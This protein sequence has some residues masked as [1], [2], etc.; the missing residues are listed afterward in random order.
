MLDILRTIT[1]ELARIGVVVDP[2][3]VVEKKATTL[4]GPPPD[5]VEIFTYSFTKTNVILSWE[6]P[7]ES[8]LRYEIR[9]GTV[10]ED[11]FKLFITGNLSAV[12]DPIEV[13]I[14]TYL[15]KSI[16]SSGIRSISSTSIEV[17]VPALGL[18]DID[19]RTLENQVLL[20]WEEPIST[21]RISHYIIRREGTVLVSHNVNTFWAYSE[22]AEGTYIY[23]VST[24]D[25]AGNESLSVSVELPVSSPADFEIEDEITSNFSGI[26]SNGVV[27]D[28]GKLYINVDTTKTY[29]EHFDDNSWISPQKQIDADYNLWI[30]PTLLAGYYEEVFI[31]SQILNNVTVNLSWL[32]EIVKGNFSFGLD[33]RVSDDGNTY[34]TAFTEAVFYAVSVRYI[35]ARI[36]FTSGSDEDLLAFGNLKCSLSVKREQDGGEK[37]VL[38]SDNASGGTTVDFNKSFLSIESITVAPKATTEIKAVYNFTGG[39]NPTSFKIL[40]FAANGNAVNATVG[41]QARGIL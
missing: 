2:A 6:P 20:N 8:A 41:W 21:F 17:E 38:A 30:Q 5:E 31:F 14:T 7:N 33:I 3:P 39:S 40:A 25:I 24:V 37:F 27:G 9:I 36:T 23:G 1:D 10:W 28:D 15:I 18:V 32:F 22:I 13:G 4:T 12:L 16:S 29:Q 26:I 11:A 35:K 34:S 19:R